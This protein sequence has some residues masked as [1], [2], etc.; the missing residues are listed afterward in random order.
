VSLLAADFYRKKEQREQEALAELDR[1]DA[2]A[3]S[4]AQLQSGE[5]LPVNQL[6]KMMSEALLE[7]RQRMQ[8]AVRLAEKLLAEG[9]AQPP[10]SRELMAFEDE[11]RRDSR[12]LLSDPQWAM[13][14][15]RIVGPGLQRHALEEFI[16]SQLESNAT[17]S[18]EAK[19]DS[20]DAEGK[21]EFLEKRQTLQEL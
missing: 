21:D 14:L 8:A 4:E 6:F 18:R 19:E 10:V 20:S 13:D 17:R 5:E 2:V 7:P 1:R 15:A 3:R 12:L 9:H 16:F 11:V